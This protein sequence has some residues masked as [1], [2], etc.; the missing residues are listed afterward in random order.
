[1]IEPR[2][3]RAAF[4]PAVLALVLTMFSLQSRPRPLPQGLAADVLFD[5]RLAAGSA[6]SI[7][8]AEPD[9]R[10]GRPGDRRTA[11]LVEARLKALGFP[12]VRQDFTSAGKSLRNVIGRRAGR[13][14]RQIV[15]LAARDAAVVP[16]ATGSAADTAAL[17]EL[18]RVFGGRPTRKTLVLASVD[19]SNLG[20]VGTTKLI[21]E[22]P[23]PELVDGVLVMSDLAS[24]SRRGP[25][26]QV[27]S[28]DSR[29]GG[30]GLARTVNDSIR[31]EVEAKMGASG[32][33]G[34]I[35]RLSFPIGIGSQG[36]LIASG[37]DAVRV[38]G[39]GELP[40]EGDGPVEAINEDTIGALGRATLR[41]VT[42]LDQGPSP[43]HGPKSYVT[44]VSQVMPGWVLALLGGTLLLPVLVA[45]VDAFARARRRAIEVL[46]WLRWMGAWVAPFLAGL[47]VA[48]V[49]ALTGATPVPPPAP[50]P[51]DVLPLDGPALGALAGVAAAMGLAFLLAR[52]LA[53][54]PERSVVRPQGPGAGVAVALLV[55][56]ASLLLWLV[57]PYAGLLVVPAAHL[58][59]LALISNAEPRRRVRAL[60]LVLGALPP[61]LVALYYLVALS[62][63]PLSGAWY[64]FMLVTGHS[65]S[66][67]SALIGCLMLGALGAAAELVARSPV[68]AADEPEGAGPPLFGPGTYAGPGSLGGT[69]S[70]LRR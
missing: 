46:I 51:P 12:A 56:G 42:A 9:R 14:R 21:E 33:L 26:V 36:P 57:N 59:L 30:I 69:Q 55:S 47:A 44:A 39:S 7:A 5:G 65:V 45:A 58:W 53:G 66:V 48:E 50:V 70:A 38:S 63:D 49:L 24:P 31:Q 8:E 10:A 67:P 61:L 13:S 18:A 3:Y 32:A 16:E 6:A 23:S 4:V 37:Y 20:E 2:V 22:L 41:T 1:M 60:L 17:L 43:E 29:R 68:R 11:A 40:P 54:R 28:N 15:V 52:F 27:W 62:M 64:L 19:G 35:A 25:F 34:Q